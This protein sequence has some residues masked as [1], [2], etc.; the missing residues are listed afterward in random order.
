MDTATARQ[1]DLHRN[2]EALACP[3]ALAKRNKVRGENNSMNL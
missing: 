3:R 2:G 1:V